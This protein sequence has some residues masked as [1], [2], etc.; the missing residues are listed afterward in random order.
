MRR[1]AH[2]PP[3]SGT[4]RCAAGAHRCIHSKQATGDHMDYCLSIAIVYGGHKSHVPQAPRNKT[5]KDGCS[6]R[7]FQ[8]AHSTHN[9]S[10]MHVQQGCS[11]ESAQVTLEQP[12]QIQHKCLKP[13]TNY[14]TRS[15]SCLHSHKHGNQAERG[16]EPIQV[17]SRYVGSSK[18]PLNPGSL[19]GTLTV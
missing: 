5:S 18:Y 14:N 3:A 1:P 10:C 4:T 7:G 12:E 16:A 15:S 9:L 13:Y 11:N 19:H 2:A 6:N 17:L 8:Q